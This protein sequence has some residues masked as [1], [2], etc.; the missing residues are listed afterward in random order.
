MKLPYGIGSFLALV[1]F[2]LVC[3]F[4]CLAMSL[5]HYLFGNNTVAAAALELK[6]PGVAT[7]TFGI[8]FVLHT[9]GLGSMGLSY[10]K[11]YRRIHASDKKEPAE[12]PKNFAAR[13]LTLIWLKVKKFYDDNLSAKGLL[14]RRGRMYEVRLVAREA[15]EIPSQSYQ[16]YL[17]S[18]HLT[19]WWSVMYALIIVV[20]ILLIPIILRLKKIKTLSRRNFVLLLDAIVD[21]FLGNLR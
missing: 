18:F 7:S 11:P 6:D 14:G 20:D 17:M 10:F 9:Y 16:A 4:F 12:L 1:L 19:R 21:T 5:L 13:V 3:M 2:R 15:I 8:L